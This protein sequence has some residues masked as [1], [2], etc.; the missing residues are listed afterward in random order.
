MRIG[1]S[2][3][4]FTFLWSEVI[5]PSE[6]FPAVAYQSP[7]KF[8]SIAGVPKPNPP[9][10]YNSPSHSNPIKTPVQQTDHR[11]IFKQT[12]LSYDCQRLPSIY[13]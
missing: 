7:P 11:L 10:S 5:F 6:D 4:L 12:K 9:P 3:R 8:K 13:C 2:A 1:I